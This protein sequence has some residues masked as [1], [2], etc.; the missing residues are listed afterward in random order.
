MKNPALCSLFLSALCLFTGLKT[1]HAQNRPGDPDPDRLNQEII[2]F[3]KW[4]AK[5]SSPEDAILFVGSSSIRFWDTA[6]AF[7]DYRVI[8]RGVG[9]SHISDVM[10][11]YNR[12]I[13]RFNPSLIIL[14][15]G[16]NDIASGLAIFNV[17]EDYLK[18]LERLKQD[19]PQSPLLFISIKA[20]SSRQE[21]TE[22]FAAFN[23][24]VEAHTRTDRMLHYVDL[25][26]PLTRNG[27]PDDSYFSEDLLHLNDRGYEL[28]NER[29]GAFLSQLEEE[30]ISAGRVKN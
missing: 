4:D 24:M 8:N 22:R 23:R 27:R 9:G 11:F 16:E 17:F 20:S 1:L 30:G 10:Y 2:E 18:L 12:L 26:S 21:H 13:G 25:A 7:P 6:K 15:C 5:N 3:E 19:F 29:L 14:Y 28:W